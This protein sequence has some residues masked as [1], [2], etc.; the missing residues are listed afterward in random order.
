MRDLILSLVSTVVAWT[1]GKYSS[2]HFRSR[3][4]TWSWG[5]G[6]RRAGSVSHQ[7]LHLSEQAMHP[8]WAA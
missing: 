7:P 4:E 8:A 6:N 2:P 1:R 5:H 3:L